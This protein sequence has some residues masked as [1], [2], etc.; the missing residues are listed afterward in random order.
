MM[1]KSNV[2]LACS[3]IFL[4]LFILPHQ[5]EAFLQPPSAHHSVGLQP[6]SPLMTTTSGTGG[7]HGDGGGENGSGFDGD[8]GD[9]DE[10]FYRD[11]RR[12]KRE[13][14]GASIP[15]EQAR[16][17]A[18]R[19]EADFLAAMREQTEDFRKKKAELGSEG[20]IDSFLDMIR[21]EDE[22]RER[23]RERETGEE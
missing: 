6:A 5:T 8:G 17:S 15:P 20:A 19:A 14:L 7:F 3:S 16:R 23:E 12:A 21:E 2:Y 4:L 18:V 11:L 1:W 22:K 10:E 9:G 13:K